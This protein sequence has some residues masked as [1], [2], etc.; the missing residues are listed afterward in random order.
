[1]IRAMGGDPEKPTREQA[2]AVAMALLEPA[3]KRFRRRSASEVDAFVAS[4][5]ELLR[6]VKRETH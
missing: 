1:M 2:E 6:E 5:V 3:R 4:A